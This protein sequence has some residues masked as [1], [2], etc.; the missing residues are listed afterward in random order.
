[1]PFWHALI[2][3]RHGAEKPVDLKQLHAVVTVAE[4]GSVTRAAELL[5]IVQPAVSRQIAGLEAE[6]GVTLFDRTRHGMSPTDAGTSFVTRARRILTEVER[7]RAEIQPS[8]AK[9]TG[10]VTVGILDSVERVLAAPL[11]ETVRRSHPGIELRLAA[12]YSGHLQQWLDDGDLDMSLLYNLTTTQSIRVLPLLRDRLWAVAPATARLSAD[13]PVALDTLLRQPF[14]MPVAGQH[15][16]R[17][18]LDEARRSC[19]VDP[20]VVAQTNSMALQTHL[21]EAGHGWTILPAAGVAAD[22]AAGRLSAAPI[23]EP[24]IVRTVGLGLPRTGRTSAAVDAVVNEMLTLIR[25]IVLS[26]HWASAELLAES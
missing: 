5:H 23:V 15:G 25:S 18:L 19:T 12:A 11:V 1:M 22:V 3:S 10:I 13:R 6:L 7:A 16:I 9:V 17:M 26:Q 4:T 20:N 2:P 24:E 8:R 21:V 14:V